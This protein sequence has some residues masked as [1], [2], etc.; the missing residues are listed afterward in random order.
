[1][2]PAGVRELEQAFHAHIKESQNIPSS[3]SSYLLL[4]Y[5]AECGV[6]SIWLRR[7]RLM[8]TDDIPEP[9][10]QGHNLHG[11]C[12]EFRIPAS[13]L[14][15]V[16]S[17]TPYFHLERDG[18]TFNIEK[19]HQVWRYGIKI[20]SQDEKNLVEWLNKL[21]DWIKENIR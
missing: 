12:K 15:S 9:D 11:W 5:A 6:K 13:Q 4:F 14:S 8:K 1:M 21:C 7:R 17:Q 10:C 2:I 18:H 20:K 19:A 16:Y 3:C